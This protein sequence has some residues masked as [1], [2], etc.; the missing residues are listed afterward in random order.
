MKKIKLAIVGSRDITDYVILKRYGIGAFRMLGF[1][2][3][4]VGKII[5]GGAKGADMLSVDLS[6]NWK[7]PH[8]SYIAEWIKPNG[9][10][11]MRAGFER[12]QFIADDCDA[13]IVLWDGESRG[14]MDTMDKFR[15]ARK[16]YIMVKV[17]R[18]NRKNPVSINFYRYNGWMKLYEETRQ[19]DPPREKP[20]RKSSKR[21][22]AV[23]RDAATRAVKIK[24]RASVRPES[25]RGDSKRTTAKKT[26][27][28]GRNRRG[29]A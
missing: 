11:N 7:I 10:K 19:P 2:M 4:D 14:T 1:V 13:A 29:K 25:R 28:R 20:V 15:E 9:S 16:P 26:A 5:S 17:D 18:V 3:A 12:N 27:D 23:T 21:P 24:S 8:L 6:L 22:P